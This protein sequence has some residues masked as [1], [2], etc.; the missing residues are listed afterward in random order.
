MH[1]AARTRAGVKRLLAAGATSALRGKVDHGRGRRRSERFSDPSGE[2]ARRLDVARAE[3]TGELARESC[4]AH[5]Q[6]YSGGGR[7][8]PR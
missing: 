1:P 5:P 3:S 2:G 8:A 4:E 6:S 7:V